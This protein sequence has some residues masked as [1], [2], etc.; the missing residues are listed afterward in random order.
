ML[1]TLKIVTREWF[2]LFFIGT[3]PFNQDSTDKSANG[4]N[5]EDTRGN[6]PKIQFWHEWKKFCATD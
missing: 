2:K 6:I 3:A 5:T 1:L 4:G